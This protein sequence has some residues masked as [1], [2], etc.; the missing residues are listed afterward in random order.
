[1]KDWDRAVAM[2]G[3]PGKTLFEI[4]EAV[5]RGTI[6]EMLTSDASPAQSSGPSVKKHL[7]PGQKRS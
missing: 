4:E 6:I 1:M 7:K 5:E 3:C 2:A